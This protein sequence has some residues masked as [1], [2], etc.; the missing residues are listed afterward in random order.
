M[1]EIRIKKEINK[2][3]ESSIE[4]K[5][6]KYNKIIYGDEKLSFLGLHKIRKVE[7]PKT[8]SAK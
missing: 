3:L 5:I 4:V 2:I 8:N 6:D 1:K 7:I